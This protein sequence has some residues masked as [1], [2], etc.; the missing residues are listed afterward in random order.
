VKPTA[1]IAAA[2]K[3]HPALIAM[4]SPLAYLLI[5]S[6]RHRFQVW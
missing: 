2:Q 1:K 5:V 3:I 4:R 6:D